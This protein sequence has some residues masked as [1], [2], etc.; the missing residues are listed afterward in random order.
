MVSAERKM[1][2]PHLTRAESEARC[3]CSEQL[4]AVMTVPA[5]TR[6]PAPAPVSK[7][8]TLGATLERP[9]AR[10]IQHLPGPRGY[11]ERRAEPAQDEL[12]FPGIRHGGASHE[13]TL[14]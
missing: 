14:G 5:V 1:H 13:K 6:L 8:T 12:G 3:S 11:R 4:G 7:L 9:A 2:R 10:D